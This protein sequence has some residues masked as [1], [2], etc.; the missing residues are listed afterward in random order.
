MPLA[1]LTCARLAT[2]SSHSAVPGSSGVSAS[3][4]RRGP[5]SVPRSICPVSSRRTELRR[6]L[7]SRA[8]GSRAGTG[9]AVQPMQKSVHPMDTIFQRKPLLD[10]QLRCGTHRAPACRIPH[11]LRHRLRQAMR[12]PGLDQQPGRTHFDDFGHS[13][14]LRRNAR[15]PRGHSLHQR[16]RQSFRRR[17]ADEQFERVIDRRHVG[18]KPREVDA[19]TETQS[20]DER[21]HLAH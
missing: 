1:G 9:V 20:A 4:R 19:I 5:Q 8:L 7:R 15:E 11:Q 6:R 21:A 3:R 14:H 12:L 17:S 10:S 13:A 16:E 18:L 2:E